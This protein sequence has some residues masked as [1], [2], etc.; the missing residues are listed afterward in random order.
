VDD[1]AGFLIALQRDEDVGYLGHLVSLLVRMSGTGV[2]TARPALAM[3]ASSW[4]RTR[5][6]A[7]PACSPSASWATGLSASCARPTQWAYHFSSS[8]LFSALS[9]A[10]ALTTA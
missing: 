6:S 2:Y 10:V 7:S 5:V 3:R 1:G 9:A 8:A 4:A